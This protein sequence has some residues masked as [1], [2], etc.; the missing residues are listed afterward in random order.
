MG[1]QLVF[2][3][4]FGLTIFFCE[5]AV[6]IVLALGRIFRCLHPQE[7]IFALLGVISSEN[8]NLILPL[9]LLGTL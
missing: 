6:A 8:L 9:V 1:F 5:I 4:C 7:G 2:F 3:K